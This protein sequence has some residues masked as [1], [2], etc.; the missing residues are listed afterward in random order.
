MAILEEIDDVD[1]MD[2]DPSEFDP[3][4]MLEDVTAHQQQDG[5]GPINLI[6]KADAE[7]KQQQQ[8]QQ[9]QPTQQNPM[10]Q[11]QKMM[12]QQQQQ[13]GAQGAQGQATQI[14]DSEEFK[15][16]DIQESD[17]KDWQLLYPVYFDKN[18]TVSEGRRVPLELAVENP[19][20]Q[21]IAEACKYLTL[22]SIYEAHKTHPKDWANPGR[23]RVQLKDDPAL[24]LPPHNVKNKR[25][26][27]RLVAQFMKKNPT[28]ATTPY[29]GPV[30]QK[31]TQS[32]PDFPWNPANLPPA[33]KYPR[34]WK[35]PTVL[36]I[37]S[38]A[39]SHG[40]S[41]NDMMEQMANQ[42]MPPV[43]EAPAPQKIKK[44]KVRVGR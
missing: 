7:R 34:G 15:S 11:L 41:N 3:R 28:K 33:T 42:F 8:Q 32:S 43:A 23:V 35:M 16:Q 12:Q 30:Y 6:S 2:F 22:P 27:Y 24:D 17:F 37:L 36:P 39:L 13:G 26:L 1:N 25:H 31:I 44:M 29:Y 5:R 18:K 20:G 19:L 14:F 4:K 10:E 40:E 38:P 21:T 9:Q